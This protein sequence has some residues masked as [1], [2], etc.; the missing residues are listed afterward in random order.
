MLAHVIDHSSKLVRG[1]IPVQPH[2]H[3]ALLIQKQ[4]GGSEHYL[5]IRRKLFF[6]DTVA[7]QIRDF[8]ISPHIDGNDIHG[9]AGLVTNVAQSKIGFQ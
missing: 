1:V 2:H 3:L 9:F 5:Q 7:G 4:Q 8:T 6:A